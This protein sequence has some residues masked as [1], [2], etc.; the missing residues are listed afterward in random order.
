MIRF[1]SRIVDSLSGQRLSRNEYQNWF[2]FACALQTMHT[3]R[4]I[5][6]PGRLAIGAEL[7]SNSAILYGNSQLTYNTKQALRSLRGSFHVLPSGFS[8]PNVSSSQPKFNSKFKFTLS[9]FRDVF[10]LGVA[11]SVSNQRSLETLVASSQPNRR[12]RKSA[13]KHVAGI[14]LFAASCVAKYFLSLATFCSVQKANVG[15]LVSVIG[16]HE[17]GCAWCAVQSRIG[18][19]E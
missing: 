11:R 5:L 18:C 2:I 1:I 12:Q 3:G 13:R 16:C 19:L 14:W 10:L 7:W 17:S 8:A 4:A 9:Y 6:H 15:R